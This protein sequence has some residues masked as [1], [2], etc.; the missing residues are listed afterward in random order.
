MHQGAPGAETGAL[1]RR[2]EHLG[3]RHLRLAPVPLGH[4]VGDGL[5][6]AASVIGSQ[7]HRARDDHHPRV[8]EDLLVD[9]QGE[10]WQPGG[11]ELTPTMKI[12][13]KVI[14]EKYAS[15]IEG[16]YAPA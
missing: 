13:R 10:E 7:H 6:Q 5:G 16:L 12:K 9:A 15:E 4:E 1:L 8:T 14:N 11:D 2:A 3:Q